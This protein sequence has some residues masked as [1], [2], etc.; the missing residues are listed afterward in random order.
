M[1]EHMLVVLLFKY[2]NQKIV[3][4]LKIVKKLLVFIFI[5]NLVRTIIFFLKVYLLNIFKFLFI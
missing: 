4:I 3:I 5:L 2:F 1:N